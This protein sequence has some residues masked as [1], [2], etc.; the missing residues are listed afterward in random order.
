MGTRDIII[1]LWQIQEK[2]REQNMGLYAVSIH[3]TR[4]LDTVSHDGL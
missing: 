2:G 4:A 3:L 1:L